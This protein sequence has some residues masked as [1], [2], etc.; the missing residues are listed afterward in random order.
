[1]ITLRLG[2]SILKIVGSVSA[3]FEN[4]LDPKLEE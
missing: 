1:M 4:I 2:F 3:Y